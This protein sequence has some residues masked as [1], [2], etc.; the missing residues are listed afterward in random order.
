M[1]VVFILLGLF[2]T[3][4][5]IVG[6]YI[7]VMPTTPFLILAAG[8]FARSSTRIH[9]RFARSA[10][11][12]NYVAP[13]KDRRGMTVAEKRRILTTIVLICL[14][15]FILMKNLYGRIALVLIVLIHILVFFKKIPTRPA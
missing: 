1:R 6:I 14:C 9:E 10:L 12:K 4:L 2:F 8:C 11:Y 15:S 7:P 3:G 13:Y 5:G